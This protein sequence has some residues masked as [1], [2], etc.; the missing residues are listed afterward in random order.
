MI[1]RKDRICGYFICFKAHRKILY[2][3]TNH[4]PEE[5]TK[6]S[7]LLT[8]YNLPLVTSAAWLNSKSTSGIKIYTL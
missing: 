3:A 1:E 7:E 2:F 5:I 4:H 6:W 8:P